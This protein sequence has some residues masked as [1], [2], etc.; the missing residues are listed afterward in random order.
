M[1]RIRF[2]KGLDVFQSTFLKTMNT[3]IDNCHNI[4]HNVMKSME[5]YILH[6]SSVKK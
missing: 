2:W 1:D 4:M 3:K 5:L 6:F